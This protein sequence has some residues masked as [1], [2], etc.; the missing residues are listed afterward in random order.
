M[1]LSIF[2]G[3]E[4]S[5]QDPH[6]TL[7]SVFKQVKEHIRSLIDLDEESTPVPER[8]DLTTIDLGSPI[9][10]VARDV[11]KRVFFLF[12]VIPS[13]NYQAEVTKIV[14]KLAKQSTYKNKRMVEII[15]ECEED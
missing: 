4:F 3:I 5:H 7:K 2:F 9:E 13:T 15:E 8:L 1:R 11:L 14:T 6:N 12:E 10:E